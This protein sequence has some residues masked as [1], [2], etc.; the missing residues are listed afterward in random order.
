MPVGNFGASSPFVL[1]GAV[2][3]ERDWNAAGEGTPTDCH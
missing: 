1:F 3:G 2:G